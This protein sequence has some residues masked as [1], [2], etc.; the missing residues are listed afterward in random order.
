MVTDLERINLPS[1]LSRVTMLSCFGHYFMLVLE[2]RERYD[3]QQ[4]FFAMVQLIG[5][6]NVADNFI[7]QLEL[8]NLRRWLT[9]VAT[10]HSIHEGIQVAITSSDSHFRHQ[11]CQAVR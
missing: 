6:R 9:L 5:S 4:Q 10:S 7:C 11:L 2:K 8:I 3:G 1:S